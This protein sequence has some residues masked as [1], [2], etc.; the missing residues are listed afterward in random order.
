MLLIIDD[1]VD[2]AKDHLAHNLLP[3]RLW[4]TFLQRGVGLVNRLNQ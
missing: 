3:Y 4:W 2:D 1:V